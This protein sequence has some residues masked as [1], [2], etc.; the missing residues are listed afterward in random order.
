[1]AADEVTAPASQESKPDKKRILV[2]E[3]DASI[4]QLI[5]EVLNSEGHD[6][7][8]VDNGV[9]AMLSI[10]QHEYDLIFSDIK[11]PKWS[12]IELFNDLKR[13]GH[14]LEKRIVFVTGDLTNPDTRNFLEST[15]ARGL[16]SHST[17]RP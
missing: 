12:G 4:R 11:M 2:V 8:M 14:G 1:M 10:Q 9:S 17:S 6:V 7:D 3:D 15:D 16:A 5:G 13:Q